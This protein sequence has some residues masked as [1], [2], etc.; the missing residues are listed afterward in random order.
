MADTKKGKRFWGCPHWDV[1][2]CAGAT[3]DGSLMAQQGFN[4]LLSAYTKLLPCKECRGHFMENII[5]IP[6]S[7][8]M[9]DNHSLFFWTYLIHDKVNESHNIYHKDEP[10]K[11]SPPYEEVKSK[12][13]IPL[14]LECS[15]CH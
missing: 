11:V 8:Y 15:S 14:G 4:E 7:A 13:F 12:Y 10:P 5:A 1:L 6:P 3:Y 2:H 9:E